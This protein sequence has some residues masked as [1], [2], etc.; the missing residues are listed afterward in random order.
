MIMGCAVSVGHSVG[1][2]SV[3]ALK[4]LRDGA[5][6][7]RKAKPLEGLIVSDMVT[8]EKD[9]VEGTAP[10]VGKKVGD[11]VGTAVGVGVTHA[12]CAA[13]AV[14]PPAHTV[15]T[16]AF[17]PDTDPGAHFMHILSGEGE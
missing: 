16:L 14:L 11:D 13:L 17:A 12:V 15:H 2:G 6:V 7:G 8:G 10:G 5:R 3:G 4:G 1:A 9:T